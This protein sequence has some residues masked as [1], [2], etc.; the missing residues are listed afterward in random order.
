MPGAMEI[1]ISMPQNEAASV[2]ALSHRLCPRPAAM[3]SILPAEADD[4]A[5]AADIIWK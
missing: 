5:P 3:M 1:D 2:G 4:A